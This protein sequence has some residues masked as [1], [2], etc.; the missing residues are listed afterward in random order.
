MLP[1]RRV[2][3]AAT[4]LIIVLLLVSCSGS[5]P[6]TLPADFTLTATPSTVNLTAGS[7]G[8]V[9]T[10]NASAVNGFNGTIPITIGGLPTGVTASPSTLTLAAGAQATTTLTAA[11]TATV[12]TA[13]VT[14]TGSTGSLTHIATVTANISAPAVPVPDFTLTVSPAAI[15]AVAGGTAGQVSVRA[16]AVNGLTGT[17]AV[18]IVGVPAGVTASPTSLVLTPGTAQTVTFTAS[19]AA[20]ASNSNLTFTATSGSLSHTGT[21][22]LTV[23]ST[24]ITVAPDVTTYHYNVR[25]DGVNAQETIL[26]PANVN[27]NTFG[28]LNFLTVD[29]KVDA[30]PLFLANL[31]VGGALHNTLFVATEHGSV[32]AFDADTGVVLWQK[33][34]IPTGEVPSDDHGCNQITSEIGITSTPVIDRTYGAHGGLFT[35]SMSKETN[36][37]YHQRLHALD[38]TT[39]AEIA[40]TP[41]EITATYPGAGPYSSGGVVTFNPGLYAERAA[42]LLQNG[43]LVLAFTSHCDGGQYTGW[44][45]A[46]NETTLQQTSVLNLTPNGSMGAIW[47]AGDGVAADASGNLYVLVGNGT[48][49]TTLVNGF[50]QS[51]D[52]GN[53]MLKLSNTAGKLA[54]TDYFEAYNTVANSN[55]DLDLGSGGEVL[56]DATDAA[57]TVHHLIVGAGKDRSIYV[58]DRDNLGKFNP[59]N[60]APDSNLYQQ[61][62]GQL[63]GGVFSTPV[64]FN[65]TLYYSAS[66]DAL[67]AFPLTNAKLATTPA[68]RSAITYGF[69]GTTPAVSANGTANG[70]VWALQSATSGPNVLHAYD[71]TNLANEFYNSNQAAASRDAFGNGN[72]FITPLVV[73]GKVYVG[74]TNGVAVFGLLPK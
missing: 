20:V 48:F 44:M 56:F 67:K 31:T 66:G 54:I 17:V 28:K 30:E 43:S 10:V 38:I 3:S 73:N 37:T 11:S 9:V 12:G 60:L 13:S 68:S 62:D 22:A 58:A 25:R 46:Y 64:V 51:G 5:S 2:F 47:M 65:G 26:T 18:A 59:S 7:A 63:T 39:G 33:S 35:V 14:F 29:G 15:T 40:A 24:L 71:P 57:A 42:L 72:K 21:A 6:T 4:A 61:I 53:G 32:Y 74:T 52:Y 45:M 19:A 8:Q 27:A 55:A 34:V 49:D 50:P 23:Q 36:G 70:I 69:P 16:D 41:T 1:L